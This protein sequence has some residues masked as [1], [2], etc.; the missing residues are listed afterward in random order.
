M[1]PGD[2]NE[3][4]FW[5]QMNFEWN[6][7]WIEMQFSCGVFAFCIWNMEQIDTSYPTAGFVAQM[8]RIIRF[9][10][11]ICDGFLWILNTEM[12]HHYW[13]IRPAN[14]RNQMLTFNKSNE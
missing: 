2:R 6:I 9:Q 7:L 4:G 13:I 5:K 11:P 10:S 3:L 12:L 1:I 14:D 8:S